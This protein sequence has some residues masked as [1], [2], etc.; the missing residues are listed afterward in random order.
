VDGLNLRRL[1]AL[2]DTFALLK[3]WRESK[4]N[5]QDASLHQY[6]QIAMYLFSN[7]KKGYKHTQ[8]LLNGQTTIFHWFTM[9][10]FEYFSGP[11]KKT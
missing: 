3:Y 5:Q 7:N 4:L 1:F 11:Q 2:Q 8:Q 9:S 10:K 6:M